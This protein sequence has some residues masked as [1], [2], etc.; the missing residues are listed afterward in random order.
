[1]VARL[2][3]FNP[4]SGPY[5]PAHRNELRRRGAPGVL[6]LSCFHPR[7]QSLKE[8]N[9]H[10]LFSGNPHELAF[11]AALQGLADCGIGFPLSRLPTRLGF[12]TFPSL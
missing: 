9:L 3:G 11:R 4:R 12:S 8:R 7:C 10:A 6:S 1:M 5:V 2:Q